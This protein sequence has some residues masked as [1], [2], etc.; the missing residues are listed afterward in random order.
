M[1]EGCK[2][3]SILRKYFRH[4]RRA[5][6][7]KAGVNTHPEAIFVSLPSVYDDICYVLF[8][9]LWQFTSLIIIYSVY[10]LSIVKV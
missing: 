1:L 8:F 5:D 3:W 6:Q 2:Y 10:F 7:Q 9:N 4:L